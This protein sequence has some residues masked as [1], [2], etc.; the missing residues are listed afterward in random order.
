MTK[1][2]HCERS[3]AIYIV[4]HSGLDP[5]S[6]KYLSEGHRNY[7]LPFQFATIIKLW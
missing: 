3:E 7:T 5:E 4:C 1:W 6:I 2:Y